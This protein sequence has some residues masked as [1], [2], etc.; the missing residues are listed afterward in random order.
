MLR[1][2]NYGK[3]CRGICGLIVGYGRVNDD[4]L[5]CLMSNDDTVAT[6]LGLLYNLPTVGCRLI[7]KDAA[8][9]LCMEVGSV[10]VT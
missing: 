2:P 4:S 7:M 9:G 1:N 6:Q 10:G 5:L 8:G 3:F